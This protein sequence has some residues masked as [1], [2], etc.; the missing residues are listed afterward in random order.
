LATELIIPLLKKQ[1]L[2]EGLSPEE[3]KE[4][5]AI[6]KSERF[7]EKA[8]IVEQGELKP[9]Y[10][11][12][13]SGEAIARALDEF[14][15]ERPVRFLQAGDSFGETSLLVGEPRDAT[16][17]AR[18]DLEVVY[19]EKADFDHLLSRRPEIRQKLRPRP[20]VK[21]L[22]EAPRYDWLVEGEVVVWHG[23]R[24]W[25]TLIT[26]SLLTLLTLGLLGFSGYLAYRMKMPLCGGIV[27]LFFSSWFLWSLAELWNWHYD[28]Y[29]VTNRRVA[30]IETIP[31]RVAAR[32]EAPLERIQEIDTQKA[33]PKS[34][35]GVG[36]LIIST[37]ARTRPIIFQSIN[38]PDEVGKIIQ[39]QKARAMRWERAE[40]RGRIKRRLVGEELPPP[41]PPPQPSRSSLS[42]FH[43]FI[44]EKREPGQV[45]WYTHWWML[46]RRAW[47]QAILFIISLAAF[48]L[49]FKLKG[50]FICGGFLF[51]AFCTLWFSTRLIDWAN[52][53][54]IVNAQQIVMLR[55][56]P[57]VPLI[58]PI[59][60]LSR[61]ERK[62]APLGSVQDVTTK[63]SGWGRIMG[64][65]GL[66]EMGD[67]LITTAAPGGVLEFKNIRNPL[68]VQAVIFE[69]LERYQEQQKRER[70]KETERLLEDWFQAHREIEH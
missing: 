20:E 52:E 31:Y 22:W 2:F 10:Y 44:G 61:I 13:L 7:P 37:A 33:F 30:L 57:I 55:I 1:P 34:I 19:I 42:I 18:T 8:R 43:A 48:A 45:T 4:L 49:W 54:Y 5:A 59:G 14:G 64:M 50:W 56:V 3:L 9:V 16:V 47:F 53:R 58:P 35:F 24:H 15:R 41:P 26:W 70:L 62:V 51:C 69:F 6:A 12:I 68:K 29:I 23:H 46:V 67:V 65:V 27:L 25:C 40:E 21:K 38:N 66:G 17:I 63:M 60:P 32:Q 28:R 11:I 36:D 39:E